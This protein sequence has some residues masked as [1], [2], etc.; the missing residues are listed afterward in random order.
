MA[1]WARDHSTD[2]AIRTLAFDI[3]STQQNQVGMMQG[4]LH[5]WNRATA[6]TTRMAW[7]DAEA[8]HGHVPAATSAGT[9]L[10]PG[11]ATSQEIAR[12]RGSSGA[13][14]DVYFLQLVLRHHVGGAPMAKYASEHAGLSAVRTLAAGIFTSQTAEVDTIGSML[15]E[16]GARPLS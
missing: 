3:E 9:G 16:R 12:L 15:T 4:W 13:E 5:L 7:M 6:S 8:G 2:P 10:M 11:M 14:L 1:V